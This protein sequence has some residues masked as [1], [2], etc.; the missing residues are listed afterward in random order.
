MNACQIA[1]TT[2]NCLQ[3][4]RADDGEELRHDTWLLKSREQE[5]QPDAMAANHNKI[6][7][8]EASSDRTDRDLL[9]SFDDFRVPA[10]RYE[11]IGAAES[12]HGARTFSQRISCET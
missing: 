8:H 11:T 5:I 7:N 10:D 2:S 6:G 9:T 12:R 3:T 1:L 4:G